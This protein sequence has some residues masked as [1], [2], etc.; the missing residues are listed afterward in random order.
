MD[1]TDGIGGV[2]G[3]GKKS[4]FIAA[5]TKLGDQSEEARF[6]LV[7]NVYIHKYGQEQ[8]LHHMVENYLLLNMLNI[9]SLDYPQD[10]APVN[11]NNCE[12]FTPELLQDL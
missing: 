11:W 3:V 4:P 8:Y 1:S 9:P 2:A 12:K 7:R 5:L 6:E 10:V